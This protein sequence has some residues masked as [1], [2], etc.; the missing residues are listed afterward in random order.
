MRQQS[1][2]MYLCALA[3][4]DSLVLY[5]GLLRLWLGEIT[6]TDIRNM[7]PWVCKSTLML[8]YTCS[9]VSVW[10]IVAVTVER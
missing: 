2:Y 1:I 5:V 9:D 8:G 7:S 6:G 10:L 4:F 3:V